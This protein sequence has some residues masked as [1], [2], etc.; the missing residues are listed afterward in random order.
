MCVCVCVE[1]LRNSVKFKAKLR[2]MQ[3]II[4]GFC[5]R[6]GEICDLL[7]YQ[8]TSVDNA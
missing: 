4:A 7:L 1:K 5:G 3:Y 8:V 6:V 2:F